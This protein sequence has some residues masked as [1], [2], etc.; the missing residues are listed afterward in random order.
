MW[1]TR[2]RKSQTHTGIT[3]G[4]RNHLSLLIRLEDIEDQKGPTGSTRR[5]EEEVEL[6]I[7]EDIEKPQILSGEATADWKPQGLSL[8]ATW[9]QVWS[10]RR[11]DPLPSFRR[12]NGSVRVARNRRAGFGVA[13]RVWDPSVA[14]ENQGASGGEAA[15]PNMACT[16]DTREAEFWR[17]R[18]LPVGSVICFH[19]PDETLEDKP[20]AAVLVLGTE[21]LDDGVWVTCQSLGGS[22]PEEKKRVSDYF[23]RQKNRIHICYGDPAECTLRDEEGLHLGVFRWYPAGDFTAPWLTAHSRKL[24]NKG[25]EMELL[26][27]K[28]KAL[29]PRTDG[30]GAGTEAGSEVERRLSALRKGTPPRVTFAERRIG[31]RAPAGRRDA[32]AGTGGPA[33]LSIAVRESMTPLKKVKQEVEIVDSTTDQEDEPKKKHKRDLGT[34]LAKIA[35]VRAVVQQRREDRSSKRRS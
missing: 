1:Q 24:V 22:T 21:S 2:S 33:P 18:R 32:L 35:R 34:T 29:E 4:R 9:K 28:K 27:S 30:P 5:G 19:N 12:S 8:Q 11:R 7:R 17:H 10:A 23:R 3:G 16:Y 13:P 14:S 15:K 6:D 31:P 20:T 26:A 25:K